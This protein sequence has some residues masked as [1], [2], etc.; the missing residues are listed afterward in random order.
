MKTVGLHPHLGTCKLNGK[1]GEK[2]EDRY[3]LTIVNGPQ[4]QK[5]P[6]PG[7]DKPCEERVC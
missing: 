1:G 3:Y 6:Q 4:R 2:R 7:K 5:Q